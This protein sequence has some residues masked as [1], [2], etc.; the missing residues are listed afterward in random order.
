[1]RVLLLLNAC[2]AACRYSLKNFDSAREA[3]SDMPPRSESE[4]DPVTLHNQVG[5][6]KGVMQACDASVMQG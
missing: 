4:L 2:A 5:A 3:L 1:M 6:S